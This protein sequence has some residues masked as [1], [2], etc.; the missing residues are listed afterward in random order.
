[1]TGK[2]GVHRNTDIPSSDHKNIIS[3]IS[4]KKRRLSIP[5]MGPGCLK[6][7]DFSATFFFTASIYFIVMTMYLGNSTLSR[8]A[9]LNYQRMQTNQNCHCEIHLPLVNRSGPRVLKVDEI[10]VIQKT[11]KE[12]EEE[13][14]SENDEHFSVT[15]VRAGKS[16]FGNDNMSTLRVYANYI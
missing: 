9:K 7:P 8:N 13:S 4:N 2:A 5:Q 10:T 12:V 6:R 11:R 3:V 1:M 16:I 15:E 14:S